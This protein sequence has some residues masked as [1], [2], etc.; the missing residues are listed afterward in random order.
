[1][2]EAAVQA[3][4]GRDPLLLLLLQ[5]H[6]LLVL[7]LLLCSLLLMGGCLAVV[8][9]LQAGVLLGEKG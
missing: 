1:M 6:R 2:E 4:L 9:G 8:M 5:R 7:L 3:V